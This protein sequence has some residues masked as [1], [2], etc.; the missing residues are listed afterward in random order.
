MSFRKSHSQKWT[1]NA[2][3]KPKHEQPNA[4]QSKNDCMFQ[5]RNYTTCQ[6]LK[7]Q[8]FFCNFTCLGL[9]C[10]LHLHFQHLPCSVFTLFCIC[11]SIFQKLQTLTFHAILKRFAQAFFSLLHQFFFA[12]VSSQGFVIVSLRL[13]QLWL[14]RCQK[15]CFPTRSGS[16]SPPQRQKE[17]E[18]H[19]IDG[20]SRLHLVNEG[21]A[22]WRV[23]EHSCGSSWLRRCGW[24]HGK[25]LPA[26]T[27]PLNSR[28]KRQPLHWKEK[29]LQIIKIE[30][31]CHKWVQQIETVWM[32]P[33][34]LK[35]CFLHFSLVWLWT[36]W[37]VCGM[38]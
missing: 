15:T 23:S 12:V 22:S 32:H 28:K 30:M 25:T 16:H 5:T 26:M 9:W 19:R 20:R 6:K 33:S 13:L 18:H 27:F 21:H 11:Q 36:N 38:G 4:F 7:Q 17:C 8:T 29:C 34:I 24:L 1:S 3:M 35:L 2:L 14:V 37:T 31:K 10:F